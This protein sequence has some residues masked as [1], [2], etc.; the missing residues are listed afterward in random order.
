MEIMSN[1]IPHLAWSH[2]KEHQDYQQDDRRKNGNSDSKRPN[3]V[4]V[5]LFTN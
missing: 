1:L 5:N 2:T 3:E 4:S